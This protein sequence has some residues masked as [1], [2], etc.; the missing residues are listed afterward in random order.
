MNI[1][2]N[3]VWFTRFLVGF[4]LLLATLFSAATAQDELTELRF[5]T[6]W[7]AESEHGG[8]YAAVA[9]GLYEEFG[10][11][12]EIIQG[13]PQVAGLAL[14]ASGQVDFAM[15]DAAALLFARNEGIPAVTIFG[16]FQI[17]PQGLMFHS[18][19]P[20]EDFSDLAGRSVAI[21]P[22]SAYWEFIEA[23]YALEGEVQVINY[24]GQL[25]DWLRDESR[26]TQIYVT[27]EP[28]AAVR[29]GANPSY[30]AIAD[31]GFN[32][33]ANIVV[34]T[35]EFAAE[36]PDIVRAF[37]E[38]SQEGWKRFITSPID[39]ADT[40]GELNESMSPDFVVWSNAQQV[41]YVMTEETMVDGFGTMTLER[42]Q[43]LYEQLLSLDLISEDVDPAEAFTT[44]FLP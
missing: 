20:V 2:T 19:E 32:P 33:Y 28:Y 16:T 6:N 41:P 29:E 13:G 42:W 1:V 25:A 35:E 23:E 31:S 9:D 43:E 22:G 27:S 34:V 36:N 14:L 15:T 5:V 10:L 7:F 37:V 38:A 39:Y 21:A 4:A 40:L 18:E 30:L 12:V 44:E 24:S 11:D 17:M 26:V 8:F 3:K